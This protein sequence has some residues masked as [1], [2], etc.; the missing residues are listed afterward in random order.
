MVVQ[1]G[2]KHGVLLTVVCVL[3]KCV[4]FVVFYSRLWYQRFAIREVFYM[5]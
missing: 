1:L 2:Y 5:V 3:F 4:K